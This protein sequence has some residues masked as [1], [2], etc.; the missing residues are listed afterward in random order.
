[1]CFIDCY[2]AIVSSVKMDCPLQNWNIHD[3]D[4]YYCTANSPF[5]RFMLVGLLG[6]NQSLTFS[7]S[8]VTGWTLT[9]G[10][11]SSTLL[12]KANGLTVVL[13]FSATVNNSLVTCTDFMTAKI[14]T[15]TIKGNF[16]LDSSR[17]YYW[18]FIIGPPFKIILT[19]VNY[20]INN[21]GTHKVKINWFSL[22]GAFH[23]SHYIVKTSDNRIFNVSTDTSIDIGDFEREDI[24]YNATVTGVDIAGNIVEESD[25]VFFT[26]DS[27]YF[28]YICLQIITSIKCIYYKEIINIIYQI[29][30]MQNRMFSYCFV[31]I[32]TT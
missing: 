28:Q 17:L 12:T 27:E 6:S 4:Q 13:T 30:H 29:Y 19:E 26:L 7:S 24:E 20:N 23:I 11:L 8:D 2:A 5:L 16:I 9:S 14:C 15:V 31:L 10:E 21:N 1:M 18:A 25:P 3:R 22:S 32:R